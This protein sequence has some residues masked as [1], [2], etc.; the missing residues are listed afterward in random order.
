MVEAGQK[1]S[2]AQEPHKFL[3]GF[4][5]TRGYYDR[6]SDSRRLNKVKTNRGK[7]RE[8]A[9]RVLAAGLNAALILP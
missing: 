5:K 8:R 7:K 9:L 4:S 6:L 1:V 3:L 2:C